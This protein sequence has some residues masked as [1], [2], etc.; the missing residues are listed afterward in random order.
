M[1][2]KERRGQ[3]KEAQEAIKKAANEAAKADEADGHRFRAKQL[4]EE[5]KSHGGLPSGHFHRS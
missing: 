4:A 3:A 1:N 2:R 5:G